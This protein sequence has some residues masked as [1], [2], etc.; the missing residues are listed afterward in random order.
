VR[1]EFLRNLCSD[2]VV[3]ATGLELPLTCS[4]NTEVFQST[5][6][7]IGHKNTV[8]GPTQPLIQWLLGTLPPGVK[9]ERR[10]DGHSPPSSA[11]VKNGGTIPP[12]PHMSSWYR[13]SLIKHRDNFTF[14]CQEHIRRAFA[15]IIVF[16]SRSVFTVRITAQNLIVYLK[17]VEQV[18]VDYC[19]HWI[20]QL[21]LRDTAFVTLFQ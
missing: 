15:A 4:H 6:T 8:E 10:E 18:S 7:F 5:S 21:L 13:A 11:D 2:I 1:P 20:I 14:T 3:L 9:R 19:L 12:L 16:R 17:N